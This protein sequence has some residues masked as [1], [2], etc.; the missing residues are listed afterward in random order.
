MVIFSY[1]REN[2]TI[3]RKKRG[4]F[5][6]VANITEARPAV[7]L[8]EL[9]ESVVASTIKQ[10]WMADDPKFRPIIEDSTLSVYAEVLIR[11]GVPKSDVETKTREARGTI[12]SNSAPLIDYTRSYWDTLTSLRAGIHRHRPTSANPYL[13]KV[14]KPGLERK[15]PR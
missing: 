15:L 9:H 5:L 10:P 13:D 6:N 7:P 3:P 2:L 12:D 11:T 4:F 14:L 8:N 1:N